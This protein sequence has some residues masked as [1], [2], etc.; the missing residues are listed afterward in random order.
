MWLCVGLCGAN[1]ILL[2]FC[3]PESNF[4]RPAEHLHA[5]APPSLE[6][7]GFNDKAVSSHIEVAE[8]AATTTSPSV[9]SQQ[10]GVNV[11]NI[12]NPS[13]E[14]ICLSPPKI[15]HEVRFWVTA[16]H[17]FI[18]LLSP[19]VLWG[20]FAY[21]ILLA[22]QLM[23][24]WVAAAT[25]LAMVNAKLTL[26]AFCAGSLNMPNLL[27]PPPY[28]FSGGQVGL[29]QVAAIVGFILAMF[30]GGYLSDVITARE[31]IKN[32]GKVITEQRLKSLIPL[33]WVS[34]LAC[35]LTGLAGEK[36]WAWYYIAITF[37]MREWIS[38][39]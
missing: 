34:P 30:A 2:F 10:Q 19:T 7:M 24:M 29:M 39:V 28:Y 38:P 31:I 21:G 37:G 23:M 35:L 15:N 16:A 27:I 36:L 26:D 20:I 32:K 1:L 3:L 14:E 8:V 25:V 17:P 9:E 33:W 6:E 4:T 18:L 13:F 22:P 12:S 5:V 11:V